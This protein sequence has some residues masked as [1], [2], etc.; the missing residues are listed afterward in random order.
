MLHEGMRNDVLFRMACALRR[1]GAVAETIQA[2]L[3]ADN[4]AR[5]KPPLR[6]AEI[7]AIATSAAKYPTAT[8][9]PSLAQR[10]AR[11]RRRGR[12]LRK[13]FPYRRNS[14]TG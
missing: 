5:C 9:G 6:A 12:P 13:R 14:S 7:R 1:Q 10:I 4:K 8:G 3:A 2:A 11:G